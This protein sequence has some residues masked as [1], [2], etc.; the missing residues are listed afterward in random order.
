MSTT[1][2]LDAWA[3]LAWLGGEEPAATRVNS[4]LDDATDEQ[5][6][7]PMCMINLGE[8]YYVLARTRGRDKAESVPK[9]LEAAP[10]EFTSVDDD[11][12]WAAARLKADYPI[13]YADAFA[14]AL[15]LRLGGEL[16]TGDLDFKALEHDE[17]LELHWLERK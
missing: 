7:L 13:S 16:V 3:V 15:A 12:V 6:R 8:V 11:L 2:V 10:I 17:G 14:A 9:D 4:L 1:R 5:A